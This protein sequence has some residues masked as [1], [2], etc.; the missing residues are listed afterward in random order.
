MTDAQKYT[1]IL[2]SATADQLADNILQLADKDGKIKGRDGRPH[3]AMIMAGV[4]KDIVNGTA[5]RSHLTTHYGIR[6][7][8]M[9]LHV[10][11]Q[12]ENRVKATARPETAGAKPLTPYNALRAQMAATI[13][14]GLAAE[15]LSKAWTAN[16]ALQAV[17]EILKRIQ[18]EDN[19]KN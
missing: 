18:T 1:L 9:Y 11:Y 2:E 5:D 12:E 6:A 16:L 17:D 15:H 19:P 3:N 7:Q 4:V 14:T 10:K 8:A 13:Y